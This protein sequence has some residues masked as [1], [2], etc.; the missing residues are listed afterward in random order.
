M[1]GQPTLATAR[2]VLRPFA[3]GDAADVQRFAGDPLVAATTLNIPH[4]YADGM[5][6]KWISGH[7]ENFR[8]EREI[9]WAITLDGALVGAAGLVLEKA[10]LRAELGYWIAVPH[11]NR[12]LATEAAQAVLAHAF[13]AL[14]LNKVVARHLPRNPSSGRVMLKL[15]MTLEGRQREHV[16]KGGQFEDLLEYAIL[17][18]EW[19]ARRAAE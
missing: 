10:H 4:P 19:Q 1:S 8:R 11:W 7:A 2:L 18:S 9:V 6:E 12:G 17:R 3:M 16:R 15:G 13:G 5:A 14:G